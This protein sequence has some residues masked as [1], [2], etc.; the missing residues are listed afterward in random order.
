MQCVKA[1]SRKSVGAKSWAAFIFLTGRAFGP[2]QAYHDQGCR[3]AKFVETLIGR[4]GGLCFSGLF[5]F[6][7]P[8]SFYLK[9]CQSRRLTEELN[10]PA[11]NGSHFTGV[12][13]E[14][15]EVIC[16]RSGKPCEGH[17]PT[18]CFPGLPS[19]VLVSPE[20]VKWSGS[21]PDYWAGVLVAVNSHDI[22]TMSVTAL[23]I[24]EIDS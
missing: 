17:P 18:D 7:S 4:I 2:C 19:S 23:T 24:V 6:Q 1:R 9:S 12:Y 16:V 21:S 15:S 22:T 13:A 3:A 11:S 8:G 20:A 14:R 5:Y 10:Y